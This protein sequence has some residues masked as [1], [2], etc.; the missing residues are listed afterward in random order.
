MLRSLGLFS[1]AKKMQGLGKYM[2]TD[3]S[4]WKP[5]DGQGYYFKSRTPDMLNAIGMDNGIRNGF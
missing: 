5:S 3:E 4:L 1:W 2:G